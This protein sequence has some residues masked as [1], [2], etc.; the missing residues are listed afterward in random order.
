[1]L[2]ENLKKLCINPNATIRQAMETIDRG[3][4]EIVFVLDS[5][6]RLLGTIT[7]GDIRR[8]ILSGA[9][10]GGQAS[11]FMK[12]DFTFVSNEM[13]RADVLDLMKAR[14]IQQIPVL[15]ENGRFIGIHLF[16][17]ML[18]AVPRDNWAIIMAGG[19]GERLR[20]LTDNLPKP[21]VKVAGRPILERTILHLVGFGIQR[22][23]LSINYL[24]E[25][26]QK[27]FGDGSAFGCRIDY[28]KEDQPLGTGG[29]LSLLPDRPEKPF[30]VLNGDLITQF[31]VDRMLQFHSSG[32]F[33]ATIAVYEYIHT[34]PY[35]VVEI[36][37]NY[38]RS[39]LEK[40]TQA[41]TANAGIYIFDPN[42]V[43]RVPKN[44][45]F[46]LPSLIEECL[47]KKESVGAFPLENEWADIGRKE[48]LQKAL[49]KI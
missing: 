20:P 33:T 31:N 34:V 14:F 16:R 42:L 4:C 19:R 10:L 46:P 49:G 15:D 39:I 40:P 1:M 9:T 25:I 6:G 24:G 7:D 18:G 30:L 28:L 5:D 2:P 3:S 17:E 45:F 37:N 38:I 11:Q 32:S 22:I 43:E 35:G 12:R 13:N 29:A 36:S 21:M 26:I 44:T 48:E 47:E 23:F 8:A 27:Y 41:W